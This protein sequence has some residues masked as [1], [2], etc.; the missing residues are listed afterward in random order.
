MENIPYPYLPEGREI[1]FVAIDDQFMIEAIKMH[2]QS[3]CT[4][5]PTGG[6]VVL[7]GKVIGRG[8]NAGKK[9]DICPRKDFPTGVGYNL[10]KEVCL[11]IGHSEATAIKDAI[12]NGYDP[13]GG[14]VYMYGHWWC[15]KNCW[16]AMIGAGIKNV[17][18]VQDAF[19]KFN[20]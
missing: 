4:D 20:H 12:D 13:K 16:D 3:G 5:H 10:C 8:T 11:Q 2:D 7:N 9:V 14:D 6:V 19:K 17:Y 15:C 18:L 1:K